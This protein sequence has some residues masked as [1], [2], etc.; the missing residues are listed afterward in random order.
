M[1][2]WTG[3]KKCC[4]EECKFKRG[5]QKWNVANARVSCIF[6]CFF[7]PSSVCVQ[8]PWKCHSI[9]DGHLECWLSINAIEHCDSWYV[10]KGLWACEFIVQEDSFSVFFF[11][12]VARMCG[13]CDK[14]AP[15]TF[16]R[17]SLRYASHK[18][19]S[20]TFGSRQNDSYFVCKDSTNHYH[21]FSKFFTLIYH[22]RK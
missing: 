20:I 1:M 9:Y 6:I 22:S 2:S 7:V 10:I 18:I 8:M 5:S 21:P 11:T 15:N 4:A 19:V 12:C 3:H 16:A 17:G 13:M 14:F